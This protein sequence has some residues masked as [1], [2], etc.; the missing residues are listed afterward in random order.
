M[1]A[2]LTGRLI[3]KKPDRVLIDVHGVGYQVQIPL[4]TFQELGGPDSPVQLRIHTHVR[5]D[6]LQ[7]YGFLTAQEKELF[8]HLI[9]VSGVGPRLALTL[10]SGLQCREVIA[11]IQNRDIARLTSIP[12]IGK[13]T[14]ERLVLEL[15]DKVEKIMLTASVVNPAAALQEDAVSALVNLGYARH[16]AEKAVNA[17]LGDNADPPGVEALLRSALRRLV[18]E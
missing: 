2:Q 4:S 13:K 14:A 7:L 6:A 17:A 5:E 11:S 9:S 18:R 10:L 8:E 1:I 12:G 3:E 15:R 16:I